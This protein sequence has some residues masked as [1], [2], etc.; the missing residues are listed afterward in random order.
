[1]GIVKDLARSS[2]PKGAAKT[3]SGDLYPNLGEIVDCRGSDG[4]DFSGNSGVFSFFPL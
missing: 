2:R 4:L 3:T 1:M